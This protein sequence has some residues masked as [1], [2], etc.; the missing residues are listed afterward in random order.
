MDAASWS[1]NARAK[2]ALRD[3]VRARLRTHTHA[4]TMSSGEL[5]REAIKLRTNCRTLKNNCESFHKLQR[6]TDCMFRTRRATQCCTAM[7][8]VHW[9]SAI[10]QSRECFVIDLFH[11]RPQIVATWCKRVAGSLSVSADALC[12]AARPDA[13]ESTRAARLLRHPNGVASRNG[14]AAPLVACPIPHP[15]TCAPGPTRPGANFPTR[16]HH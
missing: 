9:L 4:P 1:C 13:G 6:Y 11:A 5:S 10:T 2:A 12:L 16:K 15:R 7:V 3:R 14:G 8:L